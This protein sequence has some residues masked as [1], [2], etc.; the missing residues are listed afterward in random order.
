MSVA[1]TWC[2]IECE[3]IMVGKGMMTTEKSIRLEMQREE[4]LNVQEQ[5]QNNNLLERRTVCDQ[6]DKMEIIGGRYQ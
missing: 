1:N 5:N 6:S 2:S 3:L 4:H